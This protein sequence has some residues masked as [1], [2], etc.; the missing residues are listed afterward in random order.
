MADTKTNTAAAPNGYDKLLESFNAVGPTFLQGN[1]NYQNER[2]AYN[3]ALNLKRQSGLGFGG[4]SPEQ[5][6]HVAIGQ[7]AKTFGEG[8]RQKEYEKVNVP[9]M[10]TPQQWASTASLFASAP[11]Q[12]QKA[13]P[14]FLPG[15]KK[16]FGRP[17]EI[18]HDLFGPNTQHIDA[19][20]AQEKKDFEERIIPQINAQYG[21][22]QEVLRDRAIAAARTDLQERIVGMKAKAYESAL[23]RN[24]QNSKELYEAGMKPQFEREWQEKPYNGPPE[25]TAED[26][27]RKALMFKDPLTGKEESFSEYV[28]RHGD[29]LNYKGKNYGKQFKALYEHADLETKFALKNMF[30]KTKGNFQPYV[31]KLRTA[32]DFHKY[33]ALAESPNKY[34]KEIMGK[35]RHKR[36]MEALYDAVQTRDIDE[37][38]RIGKKYG[39]KIPKEA[40]GKGFWKE[41]VKLGVSA[42]VGLTAGYLGTP[43][44]G[45]AATTTTKS[46]LDSA[47]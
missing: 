33:T 26:R 8:P 29:K 7:E 5:Q 36:D 19:A 24:A 28:D 10:T 47:F 18:L 41:A 11:G 44:L 17:G 31:R 42:G 6:A 3:Q 2:D 4:L 1:Q 34:I 9:T 32:E 38:D 43:G 13:L 16:H 22:G 15:L 23:D 35:N 39:V 40:R 46:V 21:R 27:A 20:A 30:E 37:V 12:F 45:L 14:G 25:E